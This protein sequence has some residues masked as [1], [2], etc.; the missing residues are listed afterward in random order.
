MQEALRTRLDISTAYHPQTDVQSEHT[1]QTLKDMLR[2]V[3][4]APF[5]ALYGR[6]CRSPIM[7]AEVGEGQLIGHELVQETTEKISQ[8]KDRLKSAHDR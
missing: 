4:C 5:E 1:I 8:F 7:W 2:A 3:R 6:K